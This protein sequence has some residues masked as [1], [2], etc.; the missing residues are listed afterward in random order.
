MG[1]AAVV[2]TT[3]RARRRRWYRVAAWGRS[4]NFHPGVDIALAALAHGIVPIELGRFQTGGP[5]VGEGW[6]NSNLSFPRNFGC[7]YLGCFHRDVG[8][9]SSSFHL[10]PANRSAGK[11]LI[12]TRPCTWSG[13]RCYRNS[14]TPHLSPP[15]WWIPKEL[16]FVAKEYPSCFRFL[17]MRIP[18]LG[19]GTCHSQG[20]LGA[21]YLGCFYRDVGHPGFLGRRMRPVSAG[22]AVILT[23]PCTP[24]W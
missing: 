12:L 8:F 21:P 1:I 5:T 18:N 19:L 23:R 15:G 22:K 24:V 7:P 4:F 10:S 17:M 2:V 6:W 9:R 13:K 16:K 3:R 11:G 20:T 14:A